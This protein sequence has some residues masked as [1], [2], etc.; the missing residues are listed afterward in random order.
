MS[1]STT[2]MPPPQPQQN[3]EPNQF[4]E[5]M[6]ETFSITIQRQAQEALRQQW[7]ILQQSTQVQEQAHQ[8]QMEF[9]V[10]T[11]RASNY[12]QHRQQ[13][14]HCEIMMQQMS[15]EMTARE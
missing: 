1:L 8:Q 10:Q 7:H 3:L 2:I 6:L 12:T 11:E 14:M 4:F 13:L 5:K 9:A 15:K